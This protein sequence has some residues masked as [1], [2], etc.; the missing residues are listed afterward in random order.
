MMS[1][2]ED[3][4]KTCLGGFRQLLLVVLGGV[5][6]IVGRGDAPE[7]PKRYPVTVP[8]DPF[9]AVAKEGLIEDIDYYLA[10]L[11]EAHA[12]PFRQV[13]R[14]AFH[15]KAEAV[16]KHIRSLESPDVQLVDAYFLLQEVAAFLEDEHTSVYYNEAWDQSWP[17]AFPLQLR[18]FDEGVFVIRNLSDAGVPEQSE[19]LEIDGRPMAELIGQ[20]RKITNQTL[21]HYKRQMIEKNFGRWLQADSKIPPPWRIKFRHDSKE[22]TVEI[23]AVR[24]ETPFQRVSKTCIASMPW[25]RTDGVSLS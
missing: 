13:T 4:E 10:I 7:R 21:A 17:N 15:K 14:E 5:V 19:L 2:R 18:I 9:V 23:A 11:E 22:Q 20:Y 6:L 24:A 3:D 16:K 8:D 12:D 1:R 25:K